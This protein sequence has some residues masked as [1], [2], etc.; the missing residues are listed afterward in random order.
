MLTSVKQCIAPS[1]YCLLCCLGKDLNERNKKLSQTQHLYTH[2]HTQKKEFHPKEDGLN[3][4]CSDKKQKW[5]SCKWSISAYLHVLF[6][7]FQQLQ[8]PAKLLRPECPKK[9]VIYYPQSSAYCIVC[10]YLVV[11]GRSRDSH[12]NFKMLCSQLESWYDKK[13]MRQSNFWVKVV[14]DIFD[15]DRKKKSSYTSLKTVQF[16]PENP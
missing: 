12:C 13:V 16:F 4:S 2:T 1:S 15:S 6:L 10:P 9:Q 8:H 7:L 5:C 3:S 11:S 14:W